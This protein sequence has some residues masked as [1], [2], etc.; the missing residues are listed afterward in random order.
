MQV[1]GA[2]QK[3]D[4]GSI[5]DGFC[6]VDAD[7]GAR[8]GA[9]YRS[10]TRGAGNRYMA[11]C[12]FCGVVLS[13]RP[14][15]LAEHIIVGECQS[16]TQEAKSAY[17]NDVSRESLLKKRENLDS[18]VIKPPK[19]RSTGPRDT[20]I[21]PNSR[22]IVFA[23]D[24]FH[25]FAEELQLANPERYRHFPI[26]WGKFPDGTDRITISGFSPRNEVAGEHCLFIASF[27]NNEV[28]LSQ[29][30]VFIVLLQSFIESLTILLPFY[31]VGSCC[32]D[33]VKQKRMIGGCRN[34]GAGGSRRKSG[35]SEHVCHVVFQSSELRSTDETYVIRSSHSAKP[36]FLPW[37]LHSIIAIVCSY[38]LSSVI[39]HY[40][41]CRCISGRWSG[42]TIQRRVQSHW[43]AYHCLR[44]SAG[45]RPSNCA[46]AG[47]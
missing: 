31:P 46:C 15:R 25:S 8:W 40:D 26:E 14:E 43:I 23:C 20:R 28:T 10:T 18:H 39:G 17:V 22:Y 4:A 6:E 7:A 36:L 30:S 41:Y 27:H 21:N 47:W 45:R 3:M 1:Y 35:H 37:K 33:S 11:K 38:V 29:F 42:E 24:V 16:I 34:Y 32:R 13:G 9:F 44:Q 5:P 2:S 12:K 19:M